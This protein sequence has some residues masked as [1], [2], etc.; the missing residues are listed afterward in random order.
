MRD[1]LYAYAYKFLILFRT[2]AGYLLFDVIVVRCIIELPFFFFH[3]TS[4]FSCERNH[5]CCVRLSGEQPPRNKVNTLYTLVCC[6]SVSDRT[7][8]V[9]HRTTSSL[10][11]TASRQHS[12]TNR[13]RA[14]H[15]HSCIRIGLARSPRSEMLRNMNLHQ[16]HHPH[17]QHHH[18][19]HLHNST[20]LGRAVTP[21]M[22]TT[23]SAASAAVA[24]AVETTTPA[25]PST[26]AAASV[27][28]SGGAAG[29][30]SIYSPNI[31]FE[32]DY[33]SNYTHHNAQIVI[34]A[35]NGQQRA[36]VD[37]D[38][39]HSMS[40][41]TP[42][43][44]AFGYRTTT[45][46][47]GPPAMTEK[48]IKTSVVATADLMAGLERKGF[49]IVKSTRIVN[50][51]LAFPVSPTTLKTTL[52]GPNCNNNSATMA[53]NNLQ[54]LQLQ[55][56]KQQ[57]QLLDGGSSNSSST[58]SKGMVESLHNYSKQRCEEEMDRLRRKCA[59]ARF[60][61]DD[62]DEDDENDDDD[63][64]DED[65][66]GDD[67]IVDVEGGAVDD[68]QVDDRLIVDAPQLATAERATVVRKEAANSASPVASPS[69]PAADEKQ[70]EHHARRP[71][72]AFL[73]FCKRHRGIVRE[74]YPNLENRAITKI[75][76]DW[77][78]NIDVAE[79]E[80]FNRLAREVSAE[81]FDYTV[82]HVPI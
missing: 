59:R 2:L 79:K 20:P 35:S 77:W 18:H 26:P 40:T 36:A 51:P 48:S 7:G 22:T 42:E 16:H 80:H 61:D 54:Q 46:A 9:S 27:A 47:V 72:N 4:I 58:V 23:L 25:L 75:L 14:V 15:I 73:I 21:Q 6:C 29:G 31:S 37:A 28:I 11:T 74:K 1:Y 5:I 66:D 78:A 50:A 71:M 43:K 19:H 65:E 49:Y 81:I 33:R 82:S 52:A 56:Q 69:L 68:V 17:H 3:S 45:V 39:S 12:C 53:N 63:E 32:Q 38:G 70:P 57:H 13:T 55:Q 67:E 60:A 64:E 34:A 10:A 41:T 8:N 62:D 44:S 76:G 24:G 30:F